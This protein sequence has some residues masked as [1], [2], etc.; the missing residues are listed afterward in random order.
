[1]LEVLK[2]LL[3]DFLAA[4]LVECAPKVALHLIRVAAKTMP[5]D[6]LRAQKLSDWTADILTVEG[7][8]QKLVTAL[9][10][11]IMIP[12]IRKGYGYPIMEIDIG[13]NFMFRFGFISIIILQLGLLVIG[14]GMI[15]IFIAL[16]PWYISEDMRLNLQEIVMK[17]GR[18]MYILQYSIP[19]TF[20]FYFV[21]SS[22]QRHSLRES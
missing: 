20:I 8:I 17:G 18:S 9:W 3:L 2:I 22:F 7:N 19:L 4:F 6:E 15:F 12:S 14:S 21:K 5:T 13:D 10:I 1:M 16:W 11:V